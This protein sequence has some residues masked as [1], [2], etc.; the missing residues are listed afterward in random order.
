VF[1]RNVGRKRTQ[2]LI[3]AQIRARR[4]I[5]KK[6]PFSKFKIKLTSSDVRIVTAD[7]DMMNHIAKAVIQSLRNMMRLI[8]LLAK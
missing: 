7:S 4:A 1:V 6:H 2:N 5:S 8:K 3:K